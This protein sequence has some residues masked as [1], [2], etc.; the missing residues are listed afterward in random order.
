MMKNDF[1]V[2]LLD[3][4]LVINPELRDHDLSTPASRFIRLTLVET[5]F[6]TVLYKAYAG[7]TAVVPDAVVECTRTQAPISTRMR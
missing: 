2:V 6:S 5:M 1:Y 4:R 3:F 7:W